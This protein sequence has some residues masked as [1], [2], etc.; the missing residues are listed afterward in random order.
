MSSA[1]QIR[2]ESHLMTDAEKLVELQECYDLVLKTARRCA[3]DMAHAIDHL[4]ADLRDLWVDRVSHYELVL[5][6]TNDYR[7]HLHRE[8]DHLEFRLQREMNK[9]EELKK[10]FPDSPDQTELVF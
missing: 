3:R 6:G 10:R 7:A 4:P 5:G 2:A 1:S 9:S 8:I